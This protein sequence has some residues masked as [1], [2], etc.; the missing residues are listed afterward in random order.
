[1]KV[2]L[3]QIFCV[4][5]LKSNSVQSFS[6]DQLN[7]DCLPLTTKYKKKDP[8]NIPVKFVVPRN[9]DVEADDGAWRTLPTA[10]RLCLPSLESKNCM[11]HLHM[12]NLMREYA[13]YCR[14]VELG[15]HPV[16]SYNVVL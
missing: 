14:V 7:G 5:M 16:Q 12:H 9:L 10:T 3:F 2:L 13:G 4:K 15:Q 6:S 11:V 8:G 1:M